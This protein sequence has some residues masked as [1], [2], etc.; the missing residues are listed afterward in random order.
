MLGLLLSMANMSTSYGSYAWK[1]VPWNSLILSVILCFGVGD[2]FNC[3]RRALPRLAGGEDATCRGDAR[4]GL[5]GRTEMKKVVATIGLILLLAGCSS[6]GIFVSRQQGEALPKMGTAPEDGNY[7]LFIPGQQQELL[8]FPLKKGDPL[9]F[10]RGND[11]V[12]QW[13]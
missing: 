7:G 9:G 13:M 12:V 2:L 1:N 11:G 6:P 4:G 5:R 10:D 3:R 8:N